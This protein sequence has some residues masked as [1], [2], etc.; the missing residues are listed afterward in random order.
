MNDIKHLYILKFLLIFKP[1][2]FLY[3]YC[4]VLLSR[5]KSYEF[6][7]N[8]LINIKIIFHGLQQSP[9]KH[10]KCLTFFLYFETSRIGS[11]HE[12]S[13]DPTVRE[14]IFLENSKVLDYIP[15][16]S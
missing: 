14:N 5:V 9:S 12:Q 2:V 15:P 16:K 3:I 1:S 6:K 11:S 7:L 13:R 4:P 8:Y 10:K